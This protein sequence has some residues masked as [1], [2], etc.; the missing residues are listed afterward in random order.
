ME[1]RDHGGVRRHGDHHAGWKLPHEDTTAIH[2]KPLPAE[3]R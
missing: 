1:D 3:N 2:A